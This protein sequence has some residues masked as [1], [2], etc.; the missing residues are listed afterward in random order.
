MDSNVKVRFSQIRQIIQWPIYLFDYEGHCIDSNRVE[1]IGEVVDLPE[2]NGSETLQTGSFHWIV[3]GDQV[4][5]GLYYIAVRGIK[6]DPETTLK[7]IGL[8]FEDQLALD[9]QSNTLRNLL[10]TEKDAD[11]THEQVAEIA[12]VS[13]TYRVVLIRHESGETEGI[14]TIIDNICDACSLVTMDQQTLCM[15]VGLEG[16]PLQE[17]LSVIATELET[18]LMVSVAMAVGTQV[19]HVGKVWRSYGSAVKALQCGQDLLSD[20]HIYVYD[21]MMMYMMVDALKE[22][23]RQQ[24]YADYGDGFQ[25]LIED[26]E[27]IQTAIQFFDNNLNITETSRNLFVHRN[28]LIY[29]L[30]K[31]F[32][33][34]GM[35]LR[36]FEDAVR[37]N[38]LLILWK[39]R[40]SQ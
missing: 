7:L 2:M 19:D 23:D 40:R 28:T 9:G 20:Q 5:K 35:D 13:P 39:K 36:K 10:L 29:R 31:I 12:M 33:I 34:A 24:L 25:E 1:K 14:R 15:V 22:E 18:E 3:V 30:N 4:G 26:D 11:L 8:F 32:K 17:T 21:R 37:F 6:E 27:L 38:Y 16:E